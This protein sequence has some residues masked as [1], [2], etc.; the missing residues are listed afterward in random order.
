[1]KFIFV[2][3]T[4][5]QTHR[6]FGIAVA[7]HLCNHLQ[8]KRKKKDSKNVFKVIIEKNALKIYVYV[9][10]FKNIPIQ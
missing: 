6:H 8:L 10:A 7:T 5:A 1:M 2:L 3:R 9:D 4:N